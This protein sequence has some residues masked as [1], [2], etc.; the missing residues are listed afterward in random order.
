MGIY[1]NDLRELII[2]P[3]LDQLNEWSETTEN[4]LLGTAAQESQLG[5]R[6]QSNT[7]NGLGLYRI[8]AQTHTQIWDE[9]LVT[10]P[11]L[12][13]RI[14][15]LASQQQFLKSPHHELISN[16]SYASGVA[17]MIYKR[18]QLKLPDS[19]NI[20]ELAKCWHHYYCARDD[21]HAQK[22]SGDEWSID[23]FAQNYRNFVLCESKDLAA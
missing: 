21:Q 10:D 4:L 2:R 13:S 16:L 5:F 1:V 9:F 14:R 18:Y 11:E 17:W 19:S 8:S 7:N 20:N 3:V 15:G 12:A 23:S 22:T 6:M